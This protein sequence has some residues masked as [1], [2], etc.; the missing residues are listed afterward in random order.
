MSWQGDLVS[1][2][3]D[4]GNDDKMLIEVINMIMIHT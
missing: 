2:D 4:D 3:D 1:Y